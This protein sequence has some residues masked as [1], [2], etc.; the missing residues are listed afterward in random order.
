MSGPENKDDCPIHNMCMT[1]YVHGYG[2]TQLW[3]QDTLGVYT[4]AMQ[5]LEMYEGAM[6]HAESVDY[7]DR[8]YTQPDPVFAVPMA[9][10]SSYFIEGN[11]GYILF[12]GVWKFEKQ[13]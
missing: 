6:L 12:S 1:D 8:Y 10:S 5:G 7:K 3:A 4:N 11:M 2:W 13:K 9:F